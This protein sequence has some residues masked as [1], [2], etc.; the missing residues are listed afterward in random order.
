MNETELLQLMIINSVKEG[1]A[2]AIKPL[3]EELLA[4]I[5]KVKVLSAKI[6]K[7]Q[8]QINLQSN[9][10]LNEGGGFTKIGK[11]SGPTSF[12]STSYEHEQPGRSLESFKAQA[13]PYLRDIGK[14]GHLPDI[15]IPVELFL[16][17]PR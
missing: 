17:K 5:A 15:D 8:T 13:A 11:P 12:E 10:V 2:Q 1:V 14:D 4:E 6:L 7:E 9:A 16:K 3:K